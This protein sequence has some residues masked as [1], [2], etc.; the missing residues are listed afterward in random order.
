DG[1][2]N[3]VT[4]FL[5]ITDP[6]VAFDRNHRFYVV[7]SEHSDPTFTTTSGAIILQRFDFSSA[8]PTQA[9]FGTTHIDPVTGINDPFNTVIYRWYA[10]DAAAT[11]TLG[12][13]DN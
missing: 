9:P 7:S 10:Q 2:N 6:Q 5:Q 11:P 12:I 8:I 13:D 4:P 1:I 3:Q